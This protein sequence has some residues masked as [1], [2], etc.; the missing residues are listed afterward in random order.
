MRFL[1]FLVLSLPV[2]ASEVPEVRLGIRELLGSEAASKKARLAIVEDAKQSKETGDIADL[3]RA[4]LS[5]IGL[6][7]VSIIK[8]EQK[9]S[10]LDPYLELNVSKSSANNLIYAR[11]LAGKEVLF[12]KNIKVSDAEFRS[13]A[14]QVSREVLKSL[15]GE[16]GFFLSKIAFTLRHKGRKE[17]WIADFDGRN[18]AELTSFGG[19]LLLPSFTRDAKSLAFTCYKDGNPDLYLY[20]FADKSLKPL[21]RQQGLNSTASFDPKGEG[22]LATLSRGR[23]PNIYFLGYDGKIIHRLTSSRAIDTAPVFAPNGQEIAFTTDRSGNPQIFIMSRDGA[24]A[25]RL[26]YGFFW[27]DEAAWSSDGSLL[28][29]SGKKAIDENFQIFL[30]DPMGTRFV[31]ITTE[32]SNE[33]PGFSPDGRFLVYSSSRNG[34][35]EIFLQGIASEVPETRLLSFEGADAMEPSWSPQDLQ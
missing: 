4:D 26:T 31:Q 20:N 9:E 23:D 15:T 35:S 3:V 8:K 13:G 14:H 17:I 7:D 29:F 1:F 19:T 16:S 28:A 18:A 30:V 27:A 34:K 24:N 21:S 33:H 5:L 10:W 25:R 32:G 12:S 2:F 6:V 22:L 11:L